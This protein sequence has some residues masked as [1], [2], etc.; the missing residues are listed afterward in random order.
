MGEET[1]VDENESGG[2][3]ETASEN[4]VEEI[5]LKALVIEDDRITMKVTTAYL[6]DLG[7]EVY[8]AVCI[9]A[10]LE[11][12]R[13]NKDMRV[14]F[15]DLHL[16]D[17]SGLAFIRALGREHGYRHV[18]MFMLTM[19]TAKNAV[20]AAVKD[21][22]LGYL[23]KPVNRRQLISCLCGSGVLEDVSK[24]IEKIIEESDEQQIDTV[25]DSADAENSEVVSETSD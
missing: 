11:I 14:V 17:F 23:L 21:G 20:R 3:G 9:V 25:D 13:D 19:E 18:K 1:C 6:K 12:M 5:T 15:V 24:P 10:A 7:F 2:A 8:Q 16:D 4:E 22:A